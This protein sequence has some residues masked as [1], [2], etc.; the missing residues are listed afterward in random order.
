M[1]TKK[2]AKNQNSSMRSK[3]LVFLGI[4]IAVL[5]LGIVLAGQTKTSLPAQVQKTNP[6]LTISIT[7]SASRPGCENTGCYLPEKLSVH[8]GDT[9]TW[10]NNDRGFHTV[11]TGYYDTPD[12]MI[13]SEQIG[14]S[15][16]FSHKFENSGEF[17]Y[18]CRLHPWMEG[19]ISVS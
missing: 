13:E 3:F 10:I 16:T 9:V 12:G 2:Y 1:R 17:H 15:D 5:V 6:E 18:Y 14:A 19:T 8:S 4:A 7:M 11:T